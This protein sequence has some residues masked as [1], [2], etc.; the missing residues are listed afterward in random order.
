MLPGL[1]NADAELLAGDLRPPGLRNTVAMPD[2]QSEPPA[3]STDRGRRAPVRGSELP[4]LRNTAAKRDDQPPVF[5]IGLNP[6]QVKM[7]ENDANY[8]PMPVCSEWSETQNKHIL[9]PCYV[10]E[11]RSSEIR[12]SPH[13]LYGAATADAISTQ[14]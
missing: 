11:R 7:A 1:R 3:R 6:R 2:D 10:D 13:P 4:G 5:G 9:S 8:R 14:L 12:P